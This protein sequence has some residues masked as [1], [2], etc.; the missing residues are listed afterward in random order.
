MKILFE[1]LTKIDARDESLTMFHFENLKKPICVLFLLAF[2]IR[3][4]AAM[5][6]NR[7]SLSADPDG[8]AALA[9]NIRT[10]GVFGEG[11]TPTAF[12]PPLYPALLRAF[13]VFTPASADKGDSR[14]FYLLSQQDATALLHWI[15]GLMTVMIVYRLALI[16]N[17]SRGWAFAAAVLVAVD[18]ILLAQSRVPMTETL[19]AFLAVLIVWT[20]TLAMMPRQKS[21]LSFWGIG[22]LAGLSVLC[23]PVFFVFGIFVFLGLLNYT[24]MR[25]LMF[26]YSL[27]FLLGFVIFPLL[28]GM[29]NQAK[30]GD[31]IVTTT[32]G[33]YTLFLAN[34]D[35]LYAHN[36]HF[37]SFS[38]PWDPTEF[39]KKWEE[40]QAEDMEEYGEESGPAWELRKNELAYSSAHDVMSRSTQS[41]VFASLIRLGCFWQFLPYQTDPNESSF[42]KICRYAVGVFY[43]VELPLA[44]LGLLYTCLPLVSG[45][46]RRK[47]VSPYWSN[48]SWPVLLVVAVLLPH[49][50]YWTNMRMRAPLMTVVPIFAVIGLRVLCARKDDEPI[51]VGGPPTP[52]SDPVPEKESAAAQKAA[53]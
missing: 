46:Q 42:H 37:G 9:Q 27:A 8:Y 15:L 23:R 36:R 51:S 50:I 45:R 19:A 24:R 43:A 49:I 44:L 11:E 4:E 53:R 39:K 7:G 20:L 16:L 2:I 31:F 47:L 17:F 21:F 40:I 1:S 35:S 14:P 18:P 30:M 5:T 12:R 13:Y 22:L 34:N 38:G 32:H 41:A 48:W 3:F 10:Y 29:R 33:G 6:V 52:L 28:W 25:K 26:R